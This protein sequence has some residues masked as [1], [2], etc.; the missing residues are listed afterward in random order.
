[1][2]PHGH[3]QVDLVKDAGHLYFIKYL[4]TID[5]QINLYSRAQAA[6]VLS[7]VCDSHPK[8][9]WVG[10]RGL[11]CLHACF[12]MVLFKIWQQADHPREE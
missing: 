3:W 8:V 11:V 7:V 9:W 4:D 12:F 10:G 2:H 5:G 6:F 1:M